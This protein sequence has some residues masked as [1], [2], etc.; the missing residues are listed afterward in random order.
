M[1]RFK[2]DG[3][4]FP[5]TLYRYRI[6]LITPIIIACLL[7]SIIQP[8][9]EIREAITNKYFIY[10]TIYFI[11]TG[12]SFCYDAYKKPHKPDSIYYP[13]TIM[14]IKG[15]ACIGF[16]YYIISCNTNDWKNQEKPKQID[17]IRTT[18]TNDIGNTVAE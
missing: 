13:K 4:K 9:L 6:V 10:L 12:I 1:I 7:F 18:K 8:S 3:S 2:N 11:V 17:S 16:A 5:Y 15:L 14:L